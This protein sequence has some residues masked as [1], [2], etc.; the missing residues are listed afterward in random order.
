[1]YVVRQ[2][3][4]ETQRRLAAGN[5]VRGRREER[6]PTAQ[7]GEGR[8]LCRGASIGTEGHPNRGRHCV[9]PAWESG[10]AAFF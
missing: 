10:Q 2:R 7:S 8:F 6:L 1:M 3:I 5:A 4:R 9:L